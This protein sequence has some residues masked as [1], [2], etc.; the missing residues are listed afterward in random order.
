VSLWVAIAVFVSQSLFFP[1]IV[2]T[3][4]WDSLAAWMIS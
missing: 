4:A 2:P 1:V 3:A